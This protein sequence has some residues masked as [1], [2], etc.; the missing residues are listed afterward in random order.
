MSNKI[1]LTA[2]VLLTAAAI[3]G[4][5]A[6][7]P[8][9]EGDLAREIAGLN[10]NRD[11]GQT[12]YRQVVLLTCQYAFDNGRRTC[13]SRPVKKEIE[14]VIVDMNDA[15]VDE[16]SLGVI[17]SPPS[18]KNMA[19]LQQ[20]YHES[21]K[22]SDQWMYFPAMKKLKRIVSQSDESPKTGSVFGSE[23]AYDSVFEFFEVDI[24]M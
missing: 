9:K 5:W 8:L 3:T 18:E 2:I 14:N 10:L 11:D 7:P 6:Q 4:V 21:G 15:V 24:K 1:I 17:T 19:F 13:R 12:L 22:E 23:I 16:R 20:D